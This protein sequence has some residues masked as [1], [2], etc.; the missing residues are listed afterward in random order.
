M[1]QPLQLKQQSVDSWT[2]TNTKT[3][4]LIAWI[5]QLQ[6]KLGKSNQSFQVVI[7]GEMSREFTVFEGYDSLNEV[8]ACLEHYKVGGEA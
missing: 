8:M 6:N 5:T 4:V 7:R 3:G 2:V 1:S